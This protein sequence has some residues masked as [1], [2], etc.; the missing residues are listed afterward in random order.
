L[1]LAGRFFA[2]IALSGKILKKLMSELKA[3]EL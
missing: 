3:L 1:G 2:N